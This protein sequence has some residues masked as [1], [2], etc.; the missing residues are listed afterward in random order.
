L[1]GPILARR[2]PQAG[3]GAAAHDQRDDWS[4]QFL[5]ALACM[6]LDVAGI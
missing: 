6:T 4:S 2:R 5:L 3:A 1:L